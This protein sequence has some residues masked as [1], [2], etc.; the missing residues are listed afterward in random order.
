[1]PLSA[2]REIEIDYTVHLS[3]M[4]SLLTLLTREEYEKRALAGKTDMKPEVTD[5]TCP[6]CRG[7]IWEVRRGP[8]SEY[9][10]RIGHT[11]SPRSMLVEHFAAQE[12]VI[13][14]S[15]VALEEG[16][17]L[18]ARIADQLGPELRERLFKE[19]QQS[20]D[21]A[22]K[23]RALLAERTTFSLDQD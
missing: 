9:R 23:L 16:S 6:D 2:L 19:A 17:D 8:F 10:C 13:W 15:I 12:K 21:Q 3:E 11:Y 22:S 7:T 20:R 4:G 14:Q 1:M 18:S 5:I